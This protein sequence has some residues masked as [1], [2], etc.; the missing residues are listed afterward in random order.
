MKICVLQPSYD[1]SSC[2]YQHYD[3][4]RD[5]AR[6]LPEHEFHHEFVRKVS[7]FA[8]IQALARQGFDVFVNLCEGYRDSDVPSIDVIHALEHMGV[9][10][11]GPT[12]ALYDPPK[13]LMKIAARSSG[14]PGP[15]YV[16]ATG[17]SGVDDAL[18][19]LRFPMF[20][21]PA[22]YG[23]SIGIDDGSLVHDADALRRQVGRVASG[24]GRALI[25]EYIDGREFTVLVC[26]DP[27]P[28][29]TPLA[30][31]P[32]EFRFPPGV[33]FKTYDLKVRQFHPEC[34]VACSDAGLAARLKEAAVR[35]FRSFSGEGYAR[36]DFRVTPDGR[37]FFLEVNFACSVFYPEGHQGSADYILQYDGLGQAG[38]LRRIIDEALA[39]HRR[40]SRAYVVQPRNGS[41]AMFAARR[42]RA[43]ELVFRGEERAQRIVTRAH[44]E[45]SWSEADRDTFYRYAYPVGPDVFILWDTDPAEWAPQ[46]HACDPNTAFAGL[47]VVTTRD[48][49][50]GAELTLDY[51]TCYDSRMVPF[52]CACGSPRC[53]GRI[54]GGR[55][56]FG[57]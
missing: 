9:P 36:M 32:I 39:R 26:G 18:A 8:Q 50:P 16:A 48:V 7:A 20:V 30:L 45:S 56:L 25:E 35:V 38:F 17:V 11:T 19:H 43:G 41:Y 55:G 34:N 21:K 1:G 53:R 47:N 29:G 54:T 37:V 51:A 42:L 28:A 33:C 6:L 31:A 46:N 57:G 44:V 27:D 23:D 22:A 24:F 5:L 10:F 4:P 2:D 14:V 15:A 3:P 12:S 13:D 49:E 40:R 52:D